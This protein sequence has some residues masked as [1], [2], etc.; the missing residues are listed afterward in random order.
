MAEGPAAAVLGEIRLCGVSPKV[1]GTLPQGL[2]PKKPSSG[3]A[4]SLHARL[5]RAG[6]GGASVVL[7][8]IQSGGTH[9]ARE[10]G[11]QLDYLF[12]KA[13]WCGG[14]AVAFD[15]RRQ[16]LTPAER[17]KIVASWT[18][19]WQRSPRNGHTTHLLLSFPADVSARKARII[20][21]D[22]AADMFENPEARGDQW[23]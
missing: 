6:Q 19:Q 23:A 9:S 13:T 20:A 11:Q 7:K 5:W 12:S 3:G 2:V 10:L 8:K 1:A 18:D 17:K 4:G 21:E 16:S 22:W 15:D 14:N